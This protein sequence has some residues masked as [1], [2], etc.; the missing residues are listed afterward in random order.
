MK[1]NKTYVEPG[2]ALRGNVI[3]AQ[4]RDV[5]PIRYGQGSGSHRIQFTKLRN[6]AF[7]VI[8]MPMKWVS[9]KKNK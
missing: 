1:A 6:S 8:D 9:N 7:C 3:S 4:A 5:D 2:S